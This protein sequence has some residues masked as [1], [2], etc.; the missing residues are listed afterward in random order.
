MKSYFFYILFLFFGLL[1]KAQE[2]PQEMLYV[3]GGKTQIGNEAGEAN[4]KPTFMINI[5]PFYIDSKVVSVAD[6]RIFVKVIG[7]QTE[8]D[9]NGGGWVFDEQQNEWKWVEAANWEYPLGKN[10]PM[11]KPQEPVRQITW[12]DAKA[13]A[14]FRKKRLPTEFEL[15]FL[16]RNVDKYSIEFPSKLWEWSDSWY[17]EYGQN[18]SFSKRLNEEKTIRLGIFLPY[19][20]ANAIFSPS[21]RSAVKPNESF[22]FLGF[23]CAKSV[24]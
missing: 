11:A 12:N 20:E 3:K 21:R 16:A 24:E 17:R 2:V 8:A 5:K 1:A 4:E 23:R 10:F 14:N 13:Y 22:F 6:F 19:K 18:S 15:E 9:K 7:Y